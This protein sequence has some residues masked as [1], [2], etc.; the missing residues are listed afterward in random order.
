MFICREST[1]MFFS[2][3]V[4]I[5]FVCSSLEQLLTSISVYAHLDIRCTILGVVFGTVNVGQNDAAPPEVERIFISWENAGGRR[6]K[7][8]ILFVNPFNL[9]YRFPGH[10]K[11]TENKNKYRHSMY[12][13]VYRYMHRTHTS[14]LLLP[15][16]CKCMVKQTCEWRL[17]KYIYV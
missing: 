14:K 16:S 10:E 3:I 12:I 11:K 6:Q 2:C 15:P 4:G 17:Y 1:S 5:Q 13:Q 9:N 7:Q 8:I